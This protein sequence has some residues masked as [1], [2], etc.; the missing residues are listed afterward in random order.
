MSLTR[1]NER[2]AACTLTLELELK[3]QPVC[4]C[5][6]KLRFFSSLVGW[7]NDSS[8]GRGADAISYIVTS[9]SNYYNLLA[10]QV[11]KL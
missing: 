10:Y 7:L 1:N 6:L 4:G 9:Q 2:C 11:V 3:V 5:C 8:D